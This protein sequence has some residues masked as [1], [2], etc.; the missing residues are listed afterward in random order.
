M[1][2]EVEHSRLGPTS[3]LGSPVKFSDTPTSIKRGAPLLGEHTREILNE[4]GYS[5]SEIE[6]LAADGDVILH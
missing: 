5:N 6:A 3:T 1:V 4:H 2:V